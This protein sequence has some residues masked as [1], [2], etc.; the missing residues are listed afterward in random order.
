MNTTLSW[1]A[2]IYL[3]I[4]LSLSPTLLLGKHLPLDSVLQVK[5]L[6][7]LPLKTI[8]S[9]G[10]NNDIL[11][12]IDLTNSR[13]INFVI[14]NPSQQ[15]ITDWLAGDYTSL[16]QIFSGGGP[17][18][19]SA[20]LDSTG[21]HIEK[22]RQ[23]IK[24]VKKA[25]NFV[26]KFTGGDLQTLPIGMHKK[27]SGNSEVTIGISNIFLYPGYAKLEIYM[28]VESPRLE[29]PIFLAAPDV[30][31]SRLGGLSGDVALGLLGDFDIPVLENKALITFKSAM[32]DPDKDD[33]MRNK[34]TFAS[35][36]CDGLDVL[37][38]DT[39]L[40]LDRKKIRPANVP[41]AD[42]TS[43]VAASFI[44]NSENGLDDLYAEIDFKSPFYHVD[45]PEII[46]TI[47]KAT[48]DFSELQN[49]TTLTFPIASYDPSEEFGTIDNWQ[50][51]FIEQIGITWT[52]EFLGAEEPV[53]KTIYGKDLVFDHHGFSG[54]VGI[55][56][57]LPITKNKTIDS[58]PFSIDKLEV[59]FLRN[60]FASIEFDGLVGVPMINSSENGDP[61]EKELINYGAYLNIVD[62]KFMLSASLTEEKKLPVKMLYAAIYL[63]NTT[64]FTLSYQN[65]NA[66]I[67]AKLDGRI[68]IAEADIGGKNLDIPSVYFTNLTLSS[69][70][71]IKNTG[72]WSLGSDTLSAN[73]AGFGLNVYAMDLGA[74]LPS[75]PDL[76]IAANINFAVGD[77]LAI[78]G[79]T[80][81]RLIGDIE[82]KP[83]RQNWKFK[84]I[85]LDM[86]EISAETK[87]FKFAGQIIFFDDI[88]GYDN[89]PAFGKGFQGK[90]ELYIRSLNKR[91]GE[92]SETGVAALALFGTAV[93][94]DNSTFRYFMVDV[95]ARFS[96][97]IAM[98][99]ISL[100]GLGGGVYYRMRQSDIGTNL[101][102]SADFKP[103]AN[104]PTAYTEYIRSM[105][106]RSL[107]GARYQPADDVEI[108]I[109]LRVVIATSGNNEAFNANI[110]FNIEINH[111][112]GINHIKMDGTANFMAPISWEAPACSGV[113]VGL[114]LKYI[115]KLGPGTEED[116]TGFYASASA[117]VNVGPFRGGNSVTSVPVK[118]REAMEAVCEAAS[119]HY[120]G[121]FNMQI[122][123]DYWFFNIGEPTVGKRIAIKVGISPAKK[124]LALTGYLDIGK[125]IPPFPGLPEKVA[126]L[127]R[128]GNIL[129][130]ENVRASG[131]G[132]AFG[133][134]FDLDFDKS[135]NIFSA[136][137]KLGGGFDIMVN[138]YEGLQCF[139]T[140]PPK[141]I[142]NNYWYGA[143]QA[144][145]YVGGHIG[146]AGVE[147][148]S[149]SVAAAL[150]MKGPN[151]IYGRGAVGGRYRA[152]GGLLK[153]NCHFQIEFGKECILGPGQNQEMEIPLIVN[154]NPRDEDQGIS[155]F[156]PVEII[157]AREINKEFSV[158]DGDLKEDIYYKPQFDK[159]ELIDEDGNIYSTTM[160]PSDNGYFTQFFPEDA[161][162]ANTKY[163][164]VV[165]VDLYVK[166]SSQDNFTYLS[167]ETREPTFRTGNME[168]FIPEAN[169][170]SAYPGNGHY[171]Y[172]K[173][174]L[175]G[176]PNFLKLRQG[177]DELLTGL[178][179]TLVQ[180]IRLSTSHPESVVYLDC[181]YNTNANRIDYQLPTNL[182]GDKSYR[183]E[184]VHLSPTLF[185]EI[186]HLDQGQFATDTFPLPPLALEE[187]LIYQ[188][189]FRVSK[190]STFA[191]KI[192]AASFQ[193][194]EVSYNQVI[195]Q[196]FNNVHLANIS[197]PIGMEELIGIHDMPPFISCTAN[198][199]NT[200]WLNTY[201][202]FNMNEGE[203]A[204]GIV[205]I[206]H[207]LYDSG[208]YCDSDK[209]WPDSRYAAYDTDL[210]GAVAFMEEEIY[211]IDQYFLIL[212]NS[213]NAAT[214]TSY[215]AHH[216]V[217]LNYFVNL[218]MKSKWRV[219]EAIQ[220]EI[221]V[222]AIVAENL[223]ET[224]SDFKSDCYSAHRNNNSSGTYTRENL[225]A[226][227][228]GC[229]QDLENCFKMV[230]E[231]IS[232]EHGSFSCDRA[233]P[234]IKRPVYF[235]LSTGNYPVRIDYRIPE[236]SN[237]P[238]QSIS[239]TLVK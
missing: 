183:L 44:L 66:Q 24:K 70:E 150:Q 123:P 125:N 15:Q 156:N 172:Y 96:P 110:G 1:I 73:F 136:S 58:W 18:S 65:S 105:L 139:N 85:K 199:D 209:P 161:L 17:K 171:N 131:H 192:N 37:H 162:L 102:A 117:F 191:E 92:N 26:A 30:K 219:I 88:P 203:Y 165:K 202:N 210:E 167:S 216:E 51:V 63:N 91:D 153:G 228:G 76:R 152:L 71:L 237:T 107:S 13:Q 21:L 142:G 89:G 176:Q 160:A 201:E 93:K 127:T 31:F 231:F 208:D 20:M 233:N 6:L 52:E 29:K 62:K 35:F 101:S 145:V 194:M 99:P 23:T 54:F 204:P 205:N 128:L 229:Y 226:A 90:V 166:S 224:V 81:L 225:N 48:F 112:G 146:I 236:I 75:S 217:R 155:V 111:N 46:W 104:N 86:I 11:S 212:Y 19:K 79:G 7:P 179:D 200:D 126:S 115:F 197:E 39:R 138:K 94:A 45:K 227:Y 2:P 143:G 116:R 151:P 182:I 184:L 108:G 235:T 232:A 43:R 28:M 218:A 188:S 68:T 122:S 114:E 168:L 3:A 49:P 173:N 120:A 67:E 134:G 69:T 121:S 222:R 8:P 220:K 149:L 33:F 95:L 180:K 187:Q 206:Y 130:D 164:A 50:G 64:T 169:I 147:I 103:P 211:F 135:S 97:G 223:N 22:A 170:K 238:L 181:N 27:F 40:A 74:T 163:T 38:L 12:N 87:A 207:Q 239:K 214:G 132:F 9:V 154:V 100:Y 36:S 82:K 80:M 230:Y 193:P 78:S 60:N 175:Q 14:D 5:Q 148:L 189:Y 198:L 215:P 213:Q 57:L 34:G 186:V 42:T 234:F 157:L 221:D 177:Q 190:H 119:I 195:H 118:Y 56:N 124:L 178:G 158:Y 185:S 140:S 4:L 59:Y 10:S 196:D 84:E 72:D 133:L 113:S 98:G 144:W 53:Q 83:S 32:L 47:E 25:G 16:N 109:N 141:P 174:V 55:G 129:Q 41:I 61:K 77:K 159:V 137:L 106:G